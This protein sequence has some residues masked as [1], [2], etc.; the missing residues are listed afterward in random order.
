LLFSAGAPCSFFEHGDPFCLSGGPS[1]SPAIGADLL[2]FL[3]RSFVA[4]VFSFCAVQS[5]ATAAHE[6]KAPYEGPAFAFCCLFLTTVDCFRA[7]HRGDVLVLLFV[8]VALR[9]GGSGGLWPSPLD[10]GFEYFS[11]FSRV[12]CAM[13]FAFVIFSFE[14]QT[15][16]AAAPIVHESL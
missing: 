14:T 4:R 9:V 5:A 11:S 3:S 1:F 2:L 15:A 8:L 16:P 6:Q 7:S 12:F 10:I 13:Y